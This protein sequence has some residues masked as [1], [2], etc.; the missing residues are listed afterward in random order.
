[1]SGKRKDIDWLRDEVEE[2]FADLWQLPRLAG[3]RRGF[4]PPA[5]C[6]RT[7]DPPTITIVVEL[8]GVEPEDVHVVV[9]GAM[10]VV[11]GERRRDDSEGRVYHQME[12]EYGPFYRRVPLDE[13]VA[14][15]DAQA[16]YHRGMLTI[17]L[18]VARRAA[19][20]KVSIE[21]NAR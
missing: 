10:L 7:A 13:P 4:R 8:P 15:A 1:M 18:P 9:E 21:V 5:D 3:A 14:T 12:V 17:V 11:A 20:S 2:L 16:S 19:P 6:F